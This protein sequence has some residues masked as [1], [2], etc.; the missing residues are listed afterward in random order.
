M[1][2]VRV[3]N[4]GIYPQGNRG[5]FTPV[6]DVERMIFQMAPGHHTASLYEESTASNQRQIE[7]L[8]I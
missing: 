1:H 3:W 5:S 4:R 8:Y 6:F 2:S 7:V